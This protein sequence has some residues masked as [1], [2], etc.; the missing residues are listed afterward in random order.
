MNTRKTTEVMVVGRKNDLM[1]AQWE[2][3]GSPRRAWVTPDMIVDDRGGVAT[4]RD[5]NAGIPYGMDWTRVGPF[6]VTPVD[7]D[8][9]LKRRGIWNIEDLRA[10]PN[11]VIG[12]LMSAY[13]MDLARLLQWAKEFERMQSA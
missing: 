3:M 6:G 5:P 4:V 8:R 7:I 13:G 9:E 12:A 2:H 11:E 1:L 10:R